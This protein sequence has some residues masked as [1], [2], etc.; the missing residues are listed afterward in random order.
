MIPKLDPVQD[1][2]S[3]LR[4]TDEFLVNRAFCYQLSLLLLQQALWSVTSNPCEYQRLIV[5]SFRW[6]KDVRIQDTYFLSLLSSIPF[7]T[8]RRM[9][10]ESGYAQNTNYI[11]HLHITQ[12]A[13]TLNLQILDEKMWEQSS[14][15]NDAPLLGINSWHQRWLNKTA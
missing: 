6:S 8:W 12:I 15:M 3:C 11:C 7:V 5:S 13:Y 4:C 2:Y 9:C 14:W 1:C 10:R